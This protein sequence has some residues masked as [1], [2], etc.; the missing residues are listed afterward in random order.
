MLKLYEGH[1]TPIHVQMMNQE[2]LI[3]LFPLFQFNGNIYK[4]MHGSHLNTFKK[5]KINDSFKTIFIFLGKLFALKKFF[6]LEKFLEL[7]NCLH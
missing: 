6:I 5:D 2:D 4:P 3:K 1:M 7:K